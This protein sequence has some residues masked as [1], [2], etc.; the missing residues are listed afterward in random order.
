MLELLSMEENDLNLSDFI[1]QFW[2]KINFLEF[3]YI[4]DNSNDDLSGFIIKYN[5]K[6]MYILLSISTLYQPFLYY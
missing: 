6:C 4:G 5:S 1:K 2:L 3:D